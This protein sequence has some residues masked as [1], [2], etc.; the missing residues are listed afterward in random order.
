LALSMAREFVSSSPYFVLE[1]DDHIRF[2]R[3]YR[4][5]VESNQLSNTIQ[6][7]KAYWGLKNEGM[8]FMCL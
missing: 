1:A 7:P 3:D 8:D 4:S 6:T 5:Y 2:P